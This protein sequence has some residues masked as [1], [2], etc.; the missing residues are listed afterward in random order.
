MINVN[1]NGTEMLFNEQKDGWYTNIVNRLAISPDKQT[2]ITDP[3]Y[4][5]HIVDAPTHNFNIML[6]Q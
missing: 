3:W 5:D 1:V 4:A 6:T 2:C